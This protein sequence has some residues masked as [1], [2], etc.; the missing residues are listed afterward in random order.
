MAKRV[1]LQVALGQVVRSRRLAAGLSQEKLAE[2]ADL[3]RNEVGLIERGAHSP[4]LDS[5][6][7]V[8]R[9]LDLS[10]SELIR[11]AELHLSQARTSDGSEIRGS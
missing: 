5:L 7:A 11:E 10:A 6:A 8:A 3:H 9:A 4:S 2:A 1:S